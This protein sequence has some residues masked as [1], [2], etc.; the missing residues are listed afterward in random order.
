MGADIRVDGSS[1]TAYPSAL[2]GITVDCGDIP[3]LVPVLAVVAM[4]AAGTTEFLN[5]GRL[6]LKES[7]RLTA[8]A[9]LINDIG[10]SACECGDVLTV[11]N[12]FPSGGD[13]DSANDHRIAMS[14]AV[15]A[16]LASGEIRINNAQCVSK[17]Y[18]T[19]WE[20]FEAMK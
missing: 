5:A 10:G 17:S 11:F 18:P 20:E 9:N 14:A 15:A 8:I 6:R 2:A 4:K 3:D 19:F 1:V 7:D 13:A 12:K 16:F